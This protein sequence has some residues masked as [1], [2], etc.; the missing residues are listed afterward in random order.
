MAIGFLV[1]AS[2]QAFRISIKNT[3]T[4]V[5]MM[6]TMVVSF[7]LFKAPWVFPALIVLGG[8]ATNFSNRRIPEKETIKPRQIRWRN[9]FFFLLIF[10]VAGIF[11]ETARKQEWENRKVFNLFENFYRFGSFVFGGGDVLLPM[12]LDQYVARPQSPK[13]QLKNP[14]AI[15]V[16]RQDLLTGYVEPT[17]PEQVPPRDEND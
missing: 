2:V 1:Y 3:I 6:A 4:L 11:S 5:L 13:V 9:I 12:M 16:E 10:G 17:V 7:L 8:V 14:N 15:K